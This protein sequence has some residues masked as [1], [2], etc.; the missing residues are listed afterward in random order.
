MME[1]ENGRALSEEMQRFPMLAELPAE[2]MEAL[3]EVCRVEHFKKGDRIIREGDMGDTM[4]F[5][6]EG[7][8]NVLKTT[9]YG[10]EYVCATLKD[11]N[12]CVF[13]EVALLDH[14]CRSATVEA[15]TPCRALSVTAGDFREFCGKN[16]SA[17]CKLLM[18]LS[19][20]LCRNLRRENENLMKVY[21][22][23]VEEIE[24]R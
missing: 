23:L 6:L 5:L 11:E 2:D 14:D 4:Y 15:K 19:A 8:V 18:F 10:E 13:G 9:L 7:T 22:A 1:K 16:P 17:G 21:Q 12:H 20:N 3:L 24:D